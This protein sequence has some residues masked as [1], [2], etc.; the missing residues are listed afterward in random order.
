MKSYD[1]TL[2]A[3]AAMA[4]APP[5]PSPPPPDASSGADV[6]LDASLDA[7]FRAERVLVYATSRW[8]YVFAGT[9]D[10]TRWRVLKIAR[11]SLPDGALDAHEDASTMDDAQRLR[12]VAAIA[13]GNAASGGA[14]LVARGCALLGVL[15]LL[16]GHHLV[17]VTRRRRL[18]RLCGRDVFGVAAAEFVRV[19][20]PA[21]G[22]RPTAEGDERR[23]W[24][25]LTR[26]DLSRGFFFSH[27]YRLVATTQANCVGGARGGER[28]CERACDDF[29]DMFAWNAHLS[30]PL[31]RALGPAA[32]PRWLVPLVHGH[33]ASRRLSLFGRA[34]DVVLVA[35]RSRHFAGTRFNRRGVTRAGHVAN[36]VE[37]EQVVDCSGRW[38]PSGAASVALSAVTQTRGSVPLRWSQDASSSL[39]AR[40]SIALRRD[41]PNFRA[42]AKHF[43]R[44]HRRFG[45]PTVVLSLLK[46]QEGNGRGA[47]EETALGDEL[48]AALHRVNGDLRRGDAG[49][50]PENPRERVACAHWDFAKHAKESVKRREAA[51]DREGASAASSA[52]PDRARPPET[53]GLAGLTRVAAGAVSLVG[54]F[55]IA[56]RSRLLAAFERRATREDRAERSEPSSDPP[57]SDPSNPRSSDASP[58]ARRCAALWREA[59]CEAFTGLD[60]GADVLDFAAPSATLGGGEPR[61]TVP[62]A[63]RGS[64]P[65]DP[66]AVA[67]ATPPW[68]ASDALAAAT[69]RG[70][71]RSHCVD[72]LD[73]TNVAQFAFGLAALGAQLEALGAARDEDG[74]GA[75]DP[76]GSLAKALSEMYREVGNELALQY[77][78]SE[79]HAKEE[80]MRDAD[81]RVARRDAEKDAEKKNDADSTRSTD[82]ARR[83]AGLRR[84]LAD[85]AQRASAKL[86]TSARRYVSNAYTDADKQEGI[87]LFLGRHP[88]TRETPD[89]VGRAN[90]RAPGHHA[91]DSDDDDEGTTA[92]AQGGEEKKAARVP[93]RLPSAAAAWNWSLLRR[94]AE[95]RRDEASDDEASDD[96]ARTTYVSFDGVPKRLAVRLDAANK[97]AARARGGDG[98]VAGAAERTTCD[99][100]GEKHP[101]ASEEEAVRAEF[102]E[103]EAAASRR[104][105]D[106]SHEPATFRDED[107]AARE[108]FE[109][110]DSELRDA[111]VGGGDAKVA[112]EM[113]ALTRENAFAAR[114]NESF[115]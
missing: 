3:A 76:D 12:V 33:F 57:S 81:A 55:A 47:R 38:G 31:R 24:R 2:G 105:S 78:G 112:G 89:A 30:R 6:S 19:A 104:S 103:L 23:L 49:D 63:G 61:A 114:R 85:A 17:V 100:R 75:I 29:D 36:E 83:P 108:A 79:A 14:R 54:V 98:V 40:P 94:V 84:R 21:G 82:P 74:S 110:M 10:G 91:G 5:A 20:D 102:A 18:G 106:A 93:S 34:F 87:D 111:L 67:V 7:S 80:E 42:T 8:H 56:P 66:G 115:A 71:L 58:A 92:G 107:D 53:R 46:S 39:D 28:D 97:E 69:Q 86:A 27:A 4:G 1:K 35:R 60:E 32:L 45:A 88:A 9:G 25:L 16:G 44:H 26:V 96:D 48:A 77:G 50:S 37:T 15:R 113:R 41:D 99:A 90:A 62:G 68:R 51:K 13:A 22:A 101:A 73:R 72:C 11:E 65:W 64:K 43:E 95:A 59:R 70:V 109:R 52:R